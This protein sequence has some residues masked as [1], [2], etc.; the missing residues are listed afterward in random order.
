[1][2]RIEK[3]DTYSIPAPRV[4]FDTDFNCRCDFTLDSLTDLAQTIRDRGLEYPVVVQPAADVAGGIPDGFDWRLVAGFRRFR[5]V[6]ELLHWPE[7]PAMIRSG[8]D[9]HQAHVL[10]LTEN[11]ER[12]DLNPLEEAI[13]LSHIYPNGV[14]L[15]RASEELHRDTRWV[16]RRLLLLRMPEEVQELVRSRRVSLTY[17]EDIVAKRPTPEEQIRAAQAL[18]NAGN[19]RGKKR[20]AQLDGQK[21]VRTFRRRRNKIEINGQVGRMLNAGLSGLATRFG[22]WCAGHITDDEWEAD[23]QAELVMRG[24]PPA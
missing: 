12:T 4:Y 11:L 20:H 21:L 19:G 16:S 13:A 24:L 2:K 23:L 17:M 3:Y 1:M 5:T 7:V 9:E 6:T 15:K 10:N 14:T 22:A 18:A 8:L